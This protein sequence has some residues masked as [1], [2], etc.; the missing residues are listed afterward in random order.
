MT[1]IP[2]S[3]KLAALAKK[4]LMKNVSG[5]PANKPSRNPSSPLTDQNHVGSVLSCWQLFHQFECIENKHV[6]STQAFD[7][8]SMHFLETFQC[9]QCGD[10]WSPQMA[11]LTKCHWLH[12]ACRQNCCFP[13]SMHAQILSSWMRLPLSS[14]CRLGWDLT[15][16]FYFSSDWLPALSGFL[17]VLSQVFLHRLWP[18]FRVQF[19]LD[20]SPCLVQ[21]QRSL[22]IPSYVRTCPECSG[23]CAICSL[24]CHWPTHPL[25]GSL[26]PA[27]YSWLSRSMGCQHTNSRIA[28]PKRYRPQDV[29]H[30]ACLLLLLASAR[31]IHRCG[32]ACWKRLLASISHSIWPHHQNGLIQSRPL[33]MAQLHQCGPCL[34]EHAWKLFTTHALCQTI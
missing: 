1:K 14:T 23:V 21:F 19:L 20:N 22:G 7:Q 5:V 16:R 27:A 3:L 10:D 18:T 28:S 26:V 8:L 15:H 17:L 29:S 30:S 25:V 11:C 13:F 2:K 9:V 33:R 31:E 6:P 34:E 12:Q 24:V 32:Q 4:Q